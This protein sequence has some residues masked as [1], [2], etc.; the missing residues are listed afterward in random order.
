MKFV[1][2]YFDLVGSYLVLFW[3][4]ILFGITCM[5]LYT[6]IDISSYNYIISICFLGIIYLT[7]KFVEFNINNFKKGE[8]KKYD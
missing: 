5:K 1:N 7:I 3:I 8:M 4:I 2:K 6:I